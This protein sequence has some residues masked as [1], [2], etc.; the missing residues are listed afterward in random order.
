MHRQLADA[1]SNCIRYVLVLERTSFVES[2]CCY[3]GD[4]TAI[5][6]HSRPP[7]GIMVGLVFHPSE[8]Q[9]E[10]TSRIAGIESRGPEHRRAGG[11]FCRQRQHPLALSRVLHSDRSTRRINR[12]RETMIPLA[13]TAALIWCQQRA[14][15][16][17]SI[18][19]AEDRTYCKIMIIWRLSAL[20]LVARN[21][22][23]PRRNFAV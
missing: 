11:C 5:G 3:F 16:R 1:V 7:I 8:R 15:R 17:W 10:P 13:F 14:S 20:D 4:E 21:I 22:W 19:R 12:G 18:G 2:A 23:T 9:R 6:A